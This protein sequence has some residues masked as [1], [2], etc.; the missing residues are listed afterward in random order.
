MCE[1][2]SL[3]DGP[4]LG[5]CCIIIVSWDCQLRIIRVLLVGKGIAYD[6]KHYHFQHTF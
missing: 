2:L 4:R 6:L 3:F 5:F 1:D